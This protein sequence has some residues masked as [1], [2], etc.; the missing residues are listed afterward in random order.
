MGETAS[1][2]ENHIAAERD[3]L[4]QNI[5]T[6]DEKAREAVDWRTQFNSHPSAGLAIAFGAGVMLAKF[7]IGR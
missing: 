4:E 6:L 2:I 7:L 3:H 5:L 1:Q